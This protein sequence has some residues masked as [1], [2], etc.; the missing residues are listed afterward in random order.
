MLC[1]SRALKS[2]HYEI[3]VPVYK[4]PTYLSFL[5]LPCLKHKRA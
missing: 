5:L 3:K 2:Q 1:W 4:F